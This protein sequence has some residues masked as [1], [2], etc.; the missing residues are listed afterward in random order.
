MKLL[1][2]WTGGSAGAYLPKIRSL[3]GEVSIRDHGLHASEGRM[4]I[5]L[6]GG[7]SEGVLDV[8]SHFFEFIPE[9]QAEAEA[10]E[11]LLAHELT[12]GENYYILMTT[13][14]G[15]YRVQTFGML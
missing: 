7:T 8:I 2:I 9:N 15:L 14:S 10:P 3:F 6:E 11:T 4:T 5:P 13:V 12:Q 1:A